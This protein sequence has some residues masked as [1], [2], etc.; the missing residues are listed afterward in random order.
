MY[1]SCKHCNKLTVHT[2]QRNNRTGKKTFKCNT[3]NGLNKGLSYIERAE[4]AEKRAA[5]YQD[6][7]F[8][9]LLN[10][11]QQEMQTDESRNQN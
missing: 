9:D 6:K 11:A 5:M 1:K 2:E 8:E 3:C 4:L 7:T 10:F